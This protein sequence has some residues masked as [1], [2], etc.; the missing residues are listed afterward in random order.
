[1]NKQNFDEEDLE[2]KIR[3][4]VQQIN[5]VVKYQQM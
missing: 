2:L 4:L 5:H 3:S 1:M